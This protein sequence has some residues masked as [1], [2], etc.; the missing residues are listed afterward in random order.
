M[1]EERPMQNVEKPIREPEFVRSHDE[2]S[3]SRR[4]GYVLLALILLG[5]LMYLSKDRAATVADR[6]NPSPM[7]TGSGPAR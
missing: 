1:P 7:T 6:P 4:A 3:T 2:G 5:A